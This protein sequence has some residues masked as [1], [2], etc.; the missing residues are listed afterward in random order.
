MLYLYQNG[1]KKALTF[2][3]DDGVKSDIRLIEL[4]NKYGLKATFHLNS[5]TLGSEKKVNPED[6]KKI[7]EGHEVAIHGV[8][9]K[10]LTAMSGPDMINEILDDIDRKYS[11]KPKIGF[12]FKI[13]WG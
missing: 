13:G 3:Y 9:H 2:S 4:F 6:V 8:N 11:R 10:L 12:Y 5:G 1:K 7:Y